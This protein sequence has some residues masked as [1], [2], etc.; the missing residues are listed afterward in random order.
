[1]LRT[2]RRTLKLPPQHNLVHE[3]NRLGKKTS[4]KTKNNSKEINA[5]SKI[6]KTK[7]NS[8]EINALSKITKTLD[9][10][11]GEI[12]DSLEIIENRLDSCCKK[13]TKA[14]R[15]SG[16]TPQQKRQY[17]SYQAYKLTPQQKRQQQSSQSKKTSS[18]K[19]R[20]S[21]RMPQGLTGRVIQRPKQTS[22][23]RSP[24]KH[25]LAKKRGESW[26]VPQGPIRHRKLLQHPQ[27][28]FDWDVKGFDGSA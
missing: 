2:S 14:S 21:R 13:S 9:L 28:T 16:R 7:N 26:S 8:K 6:T 27:Q 12:Q 10:E 5:R 4:K 25:K 19:K 22:K 20:S 18:P 3:P 1:M 15:S 24:K 11:I 17:Q 23:S